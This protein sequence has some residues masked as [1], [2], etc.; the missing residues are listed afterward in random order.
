MQVHLHALGCRLNEAELEQWAAQFTA[1]GHHLVESP[2]HA[3]LVVVNTCAVTA[4]AVKKSRQ[5][6]RRARRGNPAAR[7]VVSG[8]HATLEP[9]LRHAIPAIDL[10]VP[11]RDKDRLVEI[12]RRELNLDTGSTGGYQPGAALFHRGRHRA[13]VKIQDGCR[14]RCTYCVV[15][16]AR[17]AE[18]SR[19]RADIIDQI[20]ALHSGG[21]REVVLTGVHVGGYGSDSGDDLCQ[22]IRAIL[23]QTA[24]ERLRL[25]SVEPW[26]LAPDFFTLFENP[27]LMPHL[28]L[29]LQSGCD[30]V[31][32]RMARR[33]LTGPYARLVDRAR[34]AIPAFNL[35]TDIIVGF[36]GESAEEWRRSLEFIE[37]TGFSHIHI[38]PYSA[39]P[40]TRAATLGD[41]VAPSCRQ[42]R[43]HELTELAAR[44]RSRFLRSQIGLDTRVLIESRRSGPDVTSNLWRGYTSNYVRAELATDAP[45]T[46][47]NTVLGA[48]VQAVSAD[49]R[50][51][52][53]R[54]R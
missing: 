34:A 1:A 5:I 18:R 48:T 31:L 37:A 2:E 20:N 7:L 15:T 21:V 12:V 41:P 8:C 32:R 28:H 54:P 33:C 29:P 47:E 22:L 14:H 13:F 45:A 3:D 51:V 26:D 6:I 30:S 10:L 53:V 24:L 23:A 25:A 42:S 36:P 9:G 44:L 46:L 11:N 4:E 43:V 16:L 38:F 19:A 39:R 35:S 49:G 27:R 40:G 17:G 50:G 52:E